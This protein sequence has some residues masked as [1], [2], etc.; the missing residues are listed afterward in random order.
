MF[1]SNH[2]KVTVIV[3]HVPKD[4]SNSIVVAF[5]YDAVEEPIVEPLILRYHESELQDRLWG[6]DPVKVK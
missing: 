5:V 4:N 3:L 2:E 6:F 1:R